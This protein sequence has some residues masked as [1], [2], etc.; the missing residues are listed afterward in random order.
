MSLSNPFAWLSHTAQNR[1]L[2]AL[3]ALT[4]ALMVVMSSAG[5]PLVDEAAPFG[6][7]SFEFAGDLETARAMLASWGERGRLYAALVQGLD[8]L[9]LVSYATAIALG[10]AVVARGLPRPGARAVALGVG[11]AWSLFA[12]A[13][14]DAVENYA[15]IQLLLGASSELWAPLAWWCA[16]PKFAIVAAGLVYLLAGGAWIALARARRRAAPVS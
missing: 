3:T 9:F 5:S 8:Y 1:A 14:L 15:L 12:A 10:C 13:L 6:I 2:A 4:L 16:L 11:L 7:V